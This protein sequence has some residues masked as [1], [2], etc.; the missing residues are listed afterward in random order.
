[1]T[2]S[3]F[4]GA[5]TRLRSAPAIL[6]SSVENGARSCFS[7]GSG[8]GAYLGPMLAAKPRTKRLLETIQFLLTFASAC[9]VIDTTR[10]HAAPADRPGYHAGLPQRSER[11]SDRRLGDLARSERKR[12]ESELRDA[13]EQR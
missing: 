12:R 4:N 7:F 8:A 1:M 2:Q 3:Y 9:A 10:I 6:C 5:S 11:Q 13:L